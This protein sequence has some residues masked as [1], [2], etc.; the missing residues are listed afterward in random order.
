MA[1][2]STVGNNIRSDFMSESPFPAKAGFRRS[3]A[4]EVWVIF[5]NNLGIIDGGW[6]TQSSRR[7]ARG[8]RESDFRDAPRL[9]RQADQ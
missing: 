9:D 6:K 8:T 3:N 2:T 1:K 7:K 4:P 5:Q